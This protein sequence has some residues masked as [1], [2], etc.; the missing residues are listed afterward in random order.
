MIL[1]IGEFRFPPEKVSEAQ[2][3]MA[4]VI[5]ATRAEQGC[6]TYSYAEDVLE[7]GL[8]RIS[9]QWTDRAS[10]AVHF[11]APHMAVWKQE[12]EALGISGRQVT[13]YQA[14]G[15]EAL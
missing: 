8:F 12:R 1:V 15:G 3:A 10:L 5:A 13:A 14:G 7:P 11:A 2:A 9:E 6:I 4:K